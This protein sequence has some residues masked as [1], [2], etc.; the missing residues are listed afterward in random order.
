MNLVAAST[1]RLIKVFWISDL[2][3]LI[4]SISNKSVFIH[5]KLD[6]MVLASNSTHAKLFILRHWAIEKLEKAKL[7]DTIKI[8]ISK[9]FWY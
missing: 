8:R 1:L 5:R 4:M 2:I 9:G 6:I 7:L 3:E